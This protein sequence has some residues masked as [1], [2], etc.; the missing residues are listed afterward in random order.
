M[1]AG[2]VVP[3]MRDQNLDIWLTVCETFLYMFAP[4]LEDYGTSTFRADVALWGGMPHLG[5]ARNTNDAA[6]HDLGLTC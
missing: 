4:R 2:K 5:R 3:G 6:I 1:S